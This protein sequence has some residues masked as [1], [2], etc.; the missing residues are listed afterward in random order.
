V[1]PQQ[2][3]GIELDPVRARQAIGAEVA[4]RVVE[5]DA[6]EIL[7]KLVV[8]GGS[9][10]LIITNP[11][12]K[13]ALEFAEA[14]LAVA[15]QRGVVALFLRIGFIASLRRSAFHREHPSDVFILAKRPSFT[16]DGKSDACEYAWFCFGLPSGGGHWTTLDPVARSSGR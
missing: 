7:P 10:G 5:G 3:S 9:P 8:P 16:G 1:S 12:Y 4:G 2:I 13:L 15:G 6:L 11:P 14:C